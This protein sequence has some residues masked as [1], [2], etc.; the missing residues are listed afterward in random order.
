MSRSMGDSKDRLMVRH[1][2]IRVA[3][4]A[5][6]LTDSLTP[7]SSSFSFLESER[8]FFRSELFNRLKGVGGWSTDD[9]LLL[10]AGSFLIWTFSERAGKTLERAMEEPASRRVSSWEV[11]RNRS[12]SMTHFRTVGQDT[13]KT[14]LH[15]DLLDSGCPGWRCIAPANVERSMADAEFDLIKAIA[16][17]EERAFE[18]FVR[19]YQNP[20]ISFIYRY[21]GDYYS[22]QDLTQ[23]VF[24]R[25]YRSAPAF[26]PRAKVSSWVFRIAYNLAANELKRR[27][28]M[29]LLKTRMSEESRSFP[30][31]PPPGA[32]EATNRELEERLMTAMGRLPENQRAALLL[33][34]NEGMSYLE[35][36]TVL[37]VSV[38]SVESLLFRA[39]SRLKQIMKTSPRDI[40]S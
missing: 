24:L 2:T 34:T 15:S 5:F 3:S 26:E 20:V 16:N 38:A 39:R 21:V 18:M 32:A 8:K 35:I 31:G 27:K 23:E 28:R 11:Q 40:P 29:D 9:R 36:S 22:A 30:G 17:K 10:S 12:L 33:K 7:W 1:S 37:G 25:V 4:L 14:E 6:Q 19:R 13:V